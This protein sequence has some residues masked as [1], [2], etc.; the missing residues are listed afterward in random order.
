MRR[1]DRA[2]ARRA[3][4]RDP[5]AWGEL[6]ATARP[7]VHASAARLGLAVDCDDLV[8]EV[9]LRLVRSLKTYR[10]HAPLR[11]W[12]ASIC[13]NT[14]RSAWR[15]DRRTRRLTVENHA[16]GHGYDGAFAAPDPSDVD[17]GDV[18]ARAA[19]A[20][21]CL[22]PRDREIIR[23][24][25]ILGVPIGDVA[26]QIGVR[27]G[28]VK[29]R[30]SRALAEVRLVALV[31]DGVRLERAASLARLTPTA[32]CARLRRAAQAMGAHGD[33]TGGAAIASLTAAR[34]DC[35]PPGRRDQ[36]TTG[37]RLPT[38]WNDAQKRGLAN[39]GT[40]RTSR[41][42]P[43]SACAALGA[44]GSSSQCV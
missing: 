28:T 1:E 10:G 17:V 22:T 19:V 2:L 32:A 6:L 21:R 44:P 33:A 37:H 34:R 23:L 43:S 25:V 12:I 26:R 39:S 3:A 30:L 8:Q 38:S 16:C 7:I 42:A 4:T 5:A 13:Y 14:V 36:T 9:M 15:R 35:P 20:V 18:C 31:L 40:F 11:H 41:M 24:R 29:S 27:E